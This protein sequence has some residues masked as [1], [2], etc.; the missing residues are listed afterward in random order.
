MY[1]ALF[2]A[3]GV[4]AASVFKREGAESYDQTATNGT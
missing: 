4:T 3:F 1:L 2:K